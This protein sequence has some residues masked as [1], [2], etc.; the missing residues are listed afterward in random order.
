MKI[1]QQLIGECTND[2]NADYWF[3]EFDNGR[4]SIAKQQ[5][6]VE[7]IK[8][9][10]ELCNICPIKERCLEEG[11]KL[12]NLS[13]GIWGGLLAGER[14]ESLNGNYDNNGIQTDVAKALSF[15]ERMQPLLRE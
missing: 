14:I 5:A 13:H 15:Y 10:V 12:E 1:S 9:A 6:L 2:L 4:P 11:M 3:P 7:S 8:Y